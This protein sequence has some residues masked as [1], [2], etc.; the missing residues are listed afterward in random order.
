MNKGDAN[1]EMR[2]ATLRYPTKVC[3]DWWSNNSRLTYMMREKTH[4]TAISNPDIFSCTT[5]QRKIINDINMI[6]ADPNNKG[7]EVTLL[8][9]SAY[10]MKRV[11]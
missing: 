3:R 6:Q 2:E 9:V 5:N 10:I 4:R 7:D 1:I 8:V 11:T